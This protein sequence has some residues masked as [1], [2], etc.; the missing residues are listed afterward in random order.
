LSELW[1]LA[2]RPGEESTKENK[3]NARSIT[4]RRW[5]IIGIFVDKSLVREWG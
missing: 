5:I 2:T 4:F 3:G 1:Y